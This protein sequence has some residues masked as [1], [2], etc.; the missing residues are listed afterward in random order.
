[1]NYS[2]EWD[3]STIPDAV[4]KSENGRRSSAM[5]VNPGRNP[6]LRECE[7]C[8]LPFSGRE[9]RKHIPQCNGLEA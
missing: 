4:W 9:M 5:R 6:V 2:P 7:F 8:G 1:M 3:L